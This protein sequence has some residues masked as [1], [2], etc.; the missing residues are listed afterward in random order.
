MPNPVDDLGNVRVDHVWGNMPMQPNDARE[1][2]LDPELDNHSIV[3]NGWSNFPQY[4]PNYAGDEDEGLETIVPNVRG[5]ARVAARTALTDAYLNPITNYVTPD[6]VS[7][8]NDGDVATVVLDTAYPFQIGDVVSGFYNDGDEIADSFV[9]ATITDVDG[10][11]LT[12]K[13]AEAISPN[14]DI[15]TVQGSGVFVYYRSGFDRRYVLAQ[16]EEPGTAIDVDSDVTL[17]LLQDND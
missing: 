11:T 3:Y 12:L 4:I 9:D 17:T 6:M 5:L 10:D 1:V 14:L 7:F 2:E 13:L 8:V 15:S 16:S